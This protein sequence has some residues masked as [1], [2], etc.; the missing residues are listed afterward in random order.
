MVEVNPRSTNA[1][2]NSLVFG[3]E[4]DRSDTTTRPPSG[5]GC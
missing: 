2:A 3:C 5:A 4:I 1:F